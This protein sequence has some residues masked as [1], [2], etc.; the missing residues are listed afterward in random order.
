MTRRRL[1][2]VLAAA[3][4]LGA[5][6]LVAARA[7]NVPRVATG[8]VAGILCSSTFVSGLD[9][10]RVLAETTDAMPGTGLITWALA[11]HVD[12]AHKDVTVSLLGLG[13]SHA[14]YREGF[15]C[16]L[17]HGDA[18]ADVTVPPADIK[19]PALLPDKIGRASCRERVC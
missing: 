6:V 1:I 2:L 15:G 12:R 16:Y 14:V 3:T 13:R 7:R 11:A 8:F 10:D 19:Q 17:D 4:A 9:S 18:I 5:L